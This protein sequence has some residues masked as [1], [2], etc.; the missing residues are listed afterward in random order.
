MHCLYWVENAPKHDVD[1]KEA[2]CKFIDRYVS[3]AVPAE[4]EDPDLRDIVLA[5]QQHSRKHY[6]SCRKRA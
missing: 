6:K 5:V 2:V 4:N 1:E 3:C